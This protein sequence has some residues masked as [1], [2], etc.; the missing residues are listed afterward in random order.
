MALHYFSYIKRKSVM[1][2]RSIAVRLNCCLN[3]LMYDITTHKKE[4]EK[5]TYLR[6]RQEP[7]CV[8]HDHS[9]M[10]LV[11]VLDL[12]FHNSGKGRGPYSQEI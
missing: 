2:G 3:F 5:G 7:V 12:S 6:H 1:F 4:V 11:P 10:L 9:G 8:S